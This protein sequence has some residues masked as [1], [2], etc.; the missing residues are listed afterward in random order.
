MDSE[1]QFGPIEESQPRTGIR[2]DRDR[3]FQ[4]VMVGNVGDDL[5][6]FVD[7]DTMREMEAHARTDTSVELGG[8]LLGY[9]REDAEGGPFVVVTDCLRAKEYQ[10]TRGS[11]KFT[12]D[13][14]N[15]I[16]RDRAQFDPDLEMVGW[17]HTHPGW[18]VFL[19]HMD[20]FICENF[21]QRPLDVALV[22]DPCND[23]RGWFQWVRGKSKTTRR[24]G[25]FFLMAHHARRDELEFF[26]R[27]LEGRA[28]AYLDPRYQEKS[29]AGATAGL[30]TWN[31][32]VPTLNGEQE[33]M[34]SRRWLFDIAVLGSLA[35]QLCLVGLIAWRLLAP[36]SDER[37]GRDPQVGSASIEQPAL[38]EQIEQ[39]AEQTRREVRESTL[40]DLLMEVASA[41]GEDPSLAAALAES[42]REQALLQQNLEGQ[43]ARVELLMQEL[44]RAEAAARG[45]AASRDALQQQVAELEAENGELRQIVEGLRQKLVEIDPGAQDSL[46]GN[47]WYSATSL[48]RFAPWIGG[49]I[50][51]A[52]GL[53]IGYFWGVRTLPMN[54]SYPDDMGNDSEKGTEDV[55][56][57]FDQPARGTE[58]DSA[59]LRSTSPRAGIPSDTDDR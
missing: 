27:V 26:R 31:D 25:G 7:L 24:T 5:P 8:V 54:A 50:L 56:F 4:V 35:I 15:Q 52:T 53:G 9:Q 42:R 3:H 45:W 11:F 2:P 14:W 58:V 39:L 51:L 28:P 18:G 44:E 48:K 57:G 49:L 33:T 46:A 21:F 38:P 40:Y 32:A 16:T 22:I 19:S 43:L 23:D 6:I 36:M 55:R 41:R 59:E 29:W 1:I 30:A 20:L 34:D 12:H 10:A 37:A 17:Y 13:T 47:E